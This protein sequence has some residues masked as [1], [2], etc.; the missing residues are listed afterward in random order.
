MTGHLCD[1]KNALWILFHNIHSRAMYF[2]REGKNFRAQHCGHPT[3]WAFIFFLPFLGAAAGLAT[4]A[5][6]VPRTKLKGKEFPRSARFAGLALTQEKKKSPSRF[7]FLP[8][9]PGPQCAATRAQACHSRFVLKAACGLCS[10]NFFH[11][12]ITPPAARPAY[13]ER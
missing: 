11:I 5:I 4:L 1:E 2:T 3:V 9:S 7:L 10:G 6:N 8:F 13:T 12:S